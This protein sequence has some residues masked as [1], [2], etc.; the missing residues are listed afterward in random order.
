M[1]ELTGYALG[2]D[3]GTTYS[4]AAVARGEAVEV[5]TLG[6]TAAQ[7]PS[8]VVLRED[9]EIGEIVDSL[10]VLYR[11]GLPRPLQVVAEVNEE[12]I[13]RVRNGMKVLLRTDAFLNQ[14]L[15]GT[16]S[17]IT[18][19]GDPVAKTYR[20]KVALPD[21]TPL[22]IGMSVEANIVTREKADVL[23]VPPVAVVGGDVF[24]VEG[25]RAYRRKVEVGL[26]GTRATE[27]VSGLKEGEIVLAPVPTGLA[28]G[29]RVSVTAAATK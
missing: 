18:P 8:V 11:I 16:V 10:N 6:T 23:L 3:L 22:R 4:A 14:P 25:S 1:A 20:V 17:D 2:V 21:D 13:P 29:A 15:E 5:C 24:M 7:V 9:G 28:D 19:A 26:R 12:D 27:I